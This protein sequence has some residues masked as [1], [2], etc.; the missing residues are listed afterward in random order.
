V[1]VDQTP[2]MVNTDD[3]DLGFYGLSWETLDPFVAS[4]PNG[5]VAFHA[6]PPP[7]VLAV[8]A[9]DAAT[10]YPFDLTRDLLRDHAAQD[11]R[12]VVPRLTVPVLAVGGRHSPVWP[13]ASTE[14]IGRTAP[15]GSTVV[16]EDSGHA[17]HLSQPTEFNTVLIDWLTALAH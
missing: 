5:V 1:L 2:K 4:F 17:P 6:P 16:L 12:D 8:V 11:W 15:L 13:V 3:W 10:P 14:W 9:A 7:E